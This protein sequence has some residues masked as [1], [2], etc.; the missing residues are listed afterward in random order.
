[1]S[2]SLCIA[3]AILCAAVPMGAQSNPASPLATQTPAPP[4]A[5]ATADKPPPAS[6]AQ[7]STAAQP[8]NAAQ[9][10]IPTQ[11]DAFCTGDSRTEVK[12][13]CLNLT[14]LLFFV[15]GDTK[16]GKSSDQIAS[17]ASLYLD[18]LDPAT[19]KPREEVVQAV[20]EVMS[21]NAASAA[22]QA[23][24]Q[25][26]LQSANQMTTSQQ[27]GAVSSAAGTTS[28]VS[29][30]GSAAITNLAV[31]SGALTRSVNGST[32]TL[33]ANVDELYSL[34]TGTPE[35]NLGGN[36]SGFERYVLNPLGLT[37]SFSL[38][39]TSTSSVPANGQA[40]GTTQT[41]ISAVAIPSGAG[42]LTA[43]TAKYEIPTKYNP[44]STAFKTAWTKEI[45]KLKSVETSEES[46]N[47]LVLVEL[48]KDPTY[49][50]LLKKGHSQPCRDALLAD[51]IKGDKQGLIKDFDNLCWQAELGP[52]IQTASSQLVAQVQAYLNDQSTLRSAYKAAILDAA[53]TMFSA[54]YTFNKPTNQ[55]ATHDLTAIFDYTFQ[56]RGSLTFNSAAS[57]YNG[58]LPAGASYGRIHY[59]QMS[60]EYDRN[61]NTPANSY[62][63]QISFAGYWQYQ[64][65]PSVLIIPAG[66]IVPGTT[67][68][69]SN[70]TQEFVGTAGSLWV[71]Q[72]K[73]TI[74]G[75]GGVN[76][77]LAISGSNKTDLLVG[78]K[79]GG[80][81]GLSYNFSS[82]ASLFGH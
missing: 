54:Q 25:N 59:G 47:A 8:A 79:I 55:P 58:A 45:D 78:T 17:D 32:A 18:Y 81:V 48:E 44:R 19:E 75:P 80:Q 16:V 3:L 1:M 73:L 6:P 62:Q 63:T 46:A 10:A 31:D 14:R 30:A 41:S 22:L 68:A 28:L 61:L 50:A 20:A 56:D 23:E 7:A 49:Q 21:V 67:I 9:P 60:L 35:Y 15:S 43:F 33:T 42:K 37:A 53:G 13:F 74:K 26:I 29:K 27:L 76:I 4:Q 70:G 11:S 77:P 82:M 71:G 5:A 52:V 72:A 12:H 36:Q 39:Q 57:I 38:N 40:S 34:V 64:P 69:L 66:T 24:S 65:Q 2:R 51:A